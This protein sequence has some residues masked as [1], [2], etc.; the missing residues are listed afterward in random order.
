MCSCKLRR[1]R[2]SATT[3]TDLKSRIV[4]VQ[5]TLVAAPRNHLYRTGHLII[6]DGPF[7]FGSIKAKLDQLRDF[8]DDLHL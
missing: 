2:A 5:I 6:E 8:T 4:K 1:L 7:V 3:D